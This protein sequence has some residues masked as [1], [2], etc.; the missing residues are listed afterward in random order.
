[1]IDNFAAPENLPFAVALGMMFL[2]GGLQT[3][4][5]LAGI[6]LFGWIDSLL[7]DFDLPDAGADL[8]GAIDAAAHGS[9]IGD[10]FAW[11]NFGK[12]PAIM[13]FL[14][15]LFLFACIGFNLQLFIASL[16]LGLLPAA[17]AAPLSFIACIYP[18]KWGNAI[19]ARVIP[20]D[21]TMAVSRQTFVGRVATI[22]IG[23]ATH[24]R[25]AE[26][27]LKGPLGRTHYIMVL[28]DSEGI[29][30]KQG[31][32]VLLVSAREATFT[33]IPVSNPNLQTH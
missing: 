2:I 15:F 32:P 19:M 27:K 22:T 28:A 10:I 9:W 8:E 26:A 17:V 4:S 13:T 21:E 30:F 31:D 29:E 25:A 20:K 16:G 7:P 3:F 12:V 6:S 5:L 14:L 33:A 23:T 1:M 18:I 24:T 11:L